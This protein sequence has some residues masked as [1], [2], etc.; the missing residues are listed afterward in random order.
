MDLVW[1]AGLGTVQSFCCCE[2]ACSVAHCWLGVAVL[3]I[4]SATHAL[5]S[6]LHRQDLQCVFVGSMWLYLKTC[7]LHCASALQQHNEACDCCEW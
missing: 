4:R 3:C 1:P 6:S 7:L 5:H 2:A